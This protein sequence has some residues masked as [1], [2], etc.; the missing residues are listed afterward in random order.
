MLEMFFKLS[1][2]SVLGTALGTGDTAV[3]MI[4]KDP[5]IMEIKL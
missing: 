1:I 4:N 2:W 5:A 3:N